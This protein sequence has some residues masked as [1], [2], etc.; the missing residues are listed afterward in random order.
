MRREVREYLPP[1]ALQ[2]LLSRAECV[3]EGG[4]EVGRPAGPEPQ[5]VYATVMITIDLASGASLF[6]EPADEATAQ[7]IAEL[8][9][10]TPGVAR[11]LVELS[12]PELAAIAGVPPGALE[13]ALE[14]HARAV[15]SQIL[16]DGDAMAVV[17][18]Q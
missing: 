8:L 15:G 13:I 16:I 5:R 1:G 3:V 18:V 2:L 11:Q 7:R 9:E 6:R 12:R 17:R 4:G 10:A 14:H